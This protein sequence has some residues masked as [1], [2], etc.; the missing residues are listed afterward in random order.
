MG[1]GV[2]VCLFC[3]VGDSFFLPRFHPFP[4][5]IYL[6]VRFFVIGIPNDNYGPLSFHAVRCFGVAF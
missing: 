4:S 5:L 1:V 3:C 6:P 2:E